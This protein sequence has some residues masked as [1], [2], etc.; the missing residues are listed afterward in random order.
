M[1]VLMSDVTL[2]A[3]KTPSP[4]P[5]PPSTKSSRYPLIDQLRGFAVILMIIYHFAYNLSTFH[6]IPY[7][8]IFDW[9]LY[10]VQRVCIITFMIC[11]G[12]SLCLAHAPKGIRWKNFF[13][14]ELQLVAASL[15]VTLATY[16]TFPQS[17]VYFGI[18]H[19][20][21]VA[22][23]VA[24]PFIQR[25]ILA[26]IIGLALL[27][28]YWLWNMTLPWF[29]LQHRPFDSVPL[30][31]WLGYVLL[32]ICAYHI[33]VQRWWHLPASALTHALEFT[34]RHTLVIYLL[35]HPILYVLVWSYWELSKL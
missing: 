11:V 33:G 21:T 17:W 32:G 16:I 2:D 31:P 8:A 20:V 12:I 5:L 6:Y 23:L 9:P 13:W 15:A 35:H 26:A 22:S 10:Q 1:V 7:Q 18:L 3:N 24:L 34:G 30:F 19:F 29:T 25:P 14:R 4:Q 27:I 28:P